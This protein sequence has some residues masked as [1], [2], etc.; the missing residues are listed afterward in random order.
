MSPGHM[1]G[2]PQCMAVREV[3]N[4][5]GDKWSLLLIQHLSAG[6]RRFSDL[7]R[8]VEGISQRMLTLTLRHLERD[9]LVSRTVYPTVP[10][11]VDYELT[12]LGRTLREPVGALASWA[13]KN[14]EKMQSA[15]DA[16]DHRAA[17]APAPGFLRARAG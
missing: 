9:G 14:R 2:T 7:K 17:S 13:G 12:P 6:P 3:L 11:R 16:F 10:P 4:L 8:M 5:V 15:R 1:K